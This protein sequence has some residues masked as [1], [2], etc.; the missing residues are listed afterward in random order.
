MMRIPTVA[1]SPE[2]ELLPAEREVIDKF[3]VEMT[4]ALREVGPALTD[5]DPERDPVEKAGANCGDLLLPLL[6]L[7]LLLLLSWNGSLN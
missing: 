3:P 4:E 6:L 1:V 7:L 2:I 5:P